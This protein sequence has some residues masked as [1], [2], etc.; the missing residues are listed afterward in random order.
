MAATIEPLA[1]ISA[2]GAVTHNAS[3]HVNVYCTES[4]RDS[5]R[6]RA[7]G[8]DSKA[9]LRLSRIRRVRASNVE[10][11][12]EQHCAVDVTE[13]KKDTDELAFKASD[14]ERVAHRIAVAVADGSEIWRESQ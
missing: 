9:W 7:D 4:R 8:F 6:A 1:I 2:C 3:G 5:R 12:Y 13:S 10:D 11:P 14:V